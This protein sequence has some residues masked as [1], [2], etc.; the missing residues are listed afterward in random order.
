MKVIWQNNHTV[1]CHVNIAHPCESESNEESDADIYN[2][3]WWKD[4]VK[5]L[6]PTAIS[7]SALRLKVKCHLFSVTAIQILTEYIADTTTDPKHLHTMSVTHYKANL[8]KCF[9]NPPIL[10][11]WHHLITLQTRQHSLSVSLP[12]MNILSS[13]TLPHVI[14]NQYCLLSSMKHRGYF[15][16]CPDHSIK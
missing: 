4:R 10:C 5:F 2:K 13:F 6:R 3:G 1:I 16:E 8:K 9:Y 7:T 12:K 14:L 15:E 11:I